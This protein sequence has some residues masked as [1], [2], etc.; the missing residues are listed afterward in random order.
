L[1]DVDWF[2]KLYKKVA[3]H[4]I[5]GVPWHKSCPDKSAFSVI[6]AQE[7]DKLS[8][9][10]VQDMFAKQHI[11]VYGLP[12]RKQDFGETGILTLAPPNRVFTIQGKCYLL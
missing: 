9:F 6:E 12:C 5:A 3:K 10:E 11:L 7:F 8:A 1:A 2:N 4:Y